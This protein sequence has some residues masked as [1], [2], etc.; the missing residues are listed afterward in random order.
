MSGSLGSNVTKDFYRAVDGGEIAN[1]SVVTVVSS[2]ISVTTNRRTLW[3]QDSRYVFPS[4]EI[5]INF[6]SDSANDAAGGTGAREI[7]FLYQ[8]LNRDEIVVSATMNGTSVTSLVVTDFF[9]VVDYF[10]SDVGS[11]G[12]NNGEIFLGNGLLSAGKPANIYGTMPTND[13][14]RMQTNVNSVENGF[15]YLFVSNYFS[16]SGNKTGRVFFGGLNFVADGV[17]TGT[18]NFSVTDF[19]QIE[20]GYVGFGPIPSGTDIVT[21]VASDSGTVNVIDLTTRFVKQPS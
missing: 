18:G 3:S 5:T 1:H 9:R 17:F 19:S 11:L 4:A 13:T 6:S 2:A 12:T 10:I 16:V 15:E 7:L 20:A 14:N 21:D 8:N